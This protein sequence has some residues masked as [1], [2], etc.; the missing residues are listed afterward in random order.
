MKKF[1]IIICVL[2]VITALNYLNLD[3]ELFYVGKHS[4]SAYKLPLNIEPEFKPDFEGGF[5]LKDRH[6][7]S[8]AGKG[9]SYFLGKQE[10]IINDVV[11]YC[12][13]D[14]V[15][16]AIVNDIEGSTY[17]IKFSASTLSD[18]GSE[19]KV[20]VYRENL[21]ILF[22]RYKCVDVEAAEIRAE[23]LE[24]K[25]FFFKLASVGLSLCLAILLL[26]MIFGIRFSEQ[27]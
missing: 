16:V 22:E 19:L 25:R 9:N 5:R 10:V 26:F 17:G 18:S 2:F 7:F 20:D 21:D 13:D 12:F 23:F 4:L 11:K 24:R 6:D 27:K 15:L 14:K 1:V 3:R 8:I